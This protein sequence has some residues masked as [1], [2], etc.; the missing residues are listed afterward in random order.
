M[1]GVALAGYLAVTAVSH[2]GH[3]ELRGAEVASL[4]IGNAI[5]TPSLPHGPRNPIAPVLVHVAMNAAT[6]VHGM[7]SAVQLPP[8]A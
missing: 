2:L 8:H 4:L 3:E 7:E 6:V 5:V 1:A